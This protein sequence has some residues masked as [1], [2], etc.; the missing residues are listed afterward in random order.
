MATKPKINQKLSKYNQQ[1]R[2]GLSVKYIVIHYVGAI[3]SAK[4]NCIY[5]AGG[6]RQASAH[7]FVDSA[8][9]QSIPL[10]KAAWHCGGGYQDYGAK[11][12]DG[13]RGAT[14]HG[15][16]VNN[17]SIGIELCC[18][19]DGK[20][21]I[22]P[23]ETAIKTAIPLVRW[24]M[25]KY[26]VPASRVIRHFDVTG[27]CCPNGYVSKTAWARLHKRLTGS[28]STSTSKTKTSKTPAYP[29]V[30]LVR[31]LK[32]DQVVRLQK[33]LNKIMGAKLDT[34]GSFGPATEKV[35]FAFQ[36]RYNLEEDGK[37]GPETRRKIQE[38]LK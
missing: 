8:I 29:T 24:L 36:K 30:N 16:C 38:R 10:N 35:V 13:N 1:S 5:F 32:G 9:W 37:V 33:C 18:K 20:G 34:D 12:I 4:N 11:M 14:L 7:F 3:S 2:N 6:N 26:N 25:D 23:S 15:K 17:N 21:R 22:V 19:R 27:K 31:G 28:S